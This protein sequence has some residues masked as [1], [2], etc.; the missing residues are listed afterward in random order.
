MFFYTLPLF[1][2]QMRLVSPIELLIVLL[3]VWIF[4]FI[5][6]PEPE[7]DYCHFSPDHYLF[8]AWQGR[9]SLRWTFWPFFLILNA[10]LHV[11]DR[12]AKA[13]VLTVSSWD[14]IHF[15]L[16]FPISWWV[17]SVWRCSK[18]VKLRFWATWARLMTL[19]VF[20]EYALKLV[21]RI[22]YPRIFFICEELL[23]DYGN[24]F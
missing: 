18:N 21:I 1:F 19:A 20:L 7:A 17:V 6:L 15:I 9:A 11:T 5:T 23:L 16:L 8:S 13:S 12:L 22:D 3:T 10:L 14:D 24:C 4:L 2:S